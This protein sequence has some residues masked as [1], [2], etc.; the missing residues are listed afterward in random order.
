[1]FN[2]EI[3]LYISRVKFLI[4]IILFLF[5]FV[6]TAPTLVCFI[7]NEKSISLVLADEDENSKEDKEFKTVFIF[8]EQKSFLSF[9]QEISTEINNNY[10]IKHYKVYPSLHIIP[11]KV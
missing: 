9:S 2:L 4:K 11:P 6:Q 5:L 3:I 8:N 10:L 1:M 7:D